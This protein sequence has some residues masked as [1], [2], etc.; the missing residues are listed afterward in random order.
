MT[1]RH[2]IILLFVWQLL[3]I[4]AAFVVSI[5]SGNFHRFI[6]EL[7]LCLTFTNAMT[8]LAS[9]YYLFYTQKL[10]KLVAN[11]YIRIG[12]SVLIAVFILAITTK[13]SLGIGQI[14][15]GFDHYK[16]D[17]WHLLVIAVNLTILSVVTIILVLYFLYQKLS[18]RLEIKIRENEKLARLQTETK[19][20]LLQSKVNPH[21]LFNT[22]NTLID[23]VRKDPVEAEKMILNLSDIYRKTLMVPDKSLVTVSDEL[24]LVKEYLDIEKM[25]MGDRLSYEIK[26]DQE[27]ES[28]KIPPMIIQIVVENAIKHGISPK[29]DGGRIDIHIKKL[30]DQL[31]LSI[32]DTG[33]GI[34]PGQ[35]DNGF[36][37]PGIQQRLKLLY[38]DKA[39]LT[40]KSNKVGGTLVKIEVPYENACSYR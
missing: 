7:I 4:S 13:I 31:C 11:S 26:V 8:L 25:R 12:I 5:P 30:D 20:S 18:T 9:L 32:N 23:I 39:I 10:T 21:F 17:R 2:W 33:V 29:K 35:L 28:C 27:S 24:L 37:L 6:H 22:L 14:M 40:I 34:T 36:G 3:G 38:N 16:V 1:T 15:C 19:L